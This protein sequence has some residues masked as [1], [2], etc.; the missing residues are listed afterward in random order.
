MRGRALDGSPEGAAAGGVAKASV[1]TTN[2]EQR[3]RH[4]G[5]APVTELEQFF[6]HQVPLSEGSQLRFNSST[7]TH[8][9]MGQ[10]VCI[11]GNTEIHLFYRSGTPAPLPTG[12][13]DM[14]PEKYA[15]F[16]F[17]WLFTMHAVA[18]VEQAIAA[19]KP[20]WIRRS[21]PLGSGVWLSAAPFE[22]HISHFTEGHMMHWHIGHHRDEYPPQEQI[23]GVNFGDNQG[24]VLMQ[25]WR[26]LTGDALPP[27][28][29]SGR[30]PRVGFFTGTGGKAFW[31]QFSEGHAYVCFE[32]VNLAARLMAPAMGGLFLFDEDAETFRRELY[33]SFQTAMLPSP[34]AHLRA[35][36]IRRDR[37]SSHGR[38]FVNE[39]AIFRVL[40][41]LGLDVTYTNHAD[42]GRFEKVDFRTQIEWCANADILI[43][44]H[45]NGLL[46]MLWMKRGSAVIEILPPKMHQT[47]Y[48][49]KAFSLGLHYLPMHGR[50][51]P[52][53]RPS[54]ACSPSYTDWANAHSGTCRP[55]LVNTDIL[56]DEDALEQNL[57]TLMMAVATSKYR[58]DVAL[59]LPGYGGS[60]ADK[61][62]ARLRTCC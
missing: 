7:G 41:R 42:F 24:D 49:A 15:G 34:K 8:W 51:P 13:R 55:S 19:L 31:S 11:R 1:P 3:F 40:R 17:A 32:H 53:W 21:D 45:G 47:V 46:N 4:D 54:A 2:W 16:G 20:R 59:A 62:K 28:D 37:K 48:D 38:V 23:I 10:N 5:E 57:R 36:V 22:K 61:E 60:K 50:A 9:A 18:N 43:G 35:V 29:A 44:A 52:N 39:D 33:H 14:R 30:K 12:W 27:L 56:I 26:F 58:R 6:A 25:F